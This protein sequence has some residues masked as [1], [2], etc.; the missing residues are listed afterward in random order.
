[1][2]AQPTLSLPKEPRDS[3]QREQERTARTFRCNFPPSARVLHNTDICL[4]DTVNGSRTSGLTKVTLACVVLLS[5]T[6]GFGQ[7]GSMSPYQ[8]ER[9]GVS[10]GGKWMMF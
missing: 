9:D 10:A 5:T 2:P 8:G 3:K 1:M 4:E 7:G 6:L